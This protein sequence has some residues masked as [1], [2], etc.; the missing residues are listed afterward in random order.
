MKVL[1]VSDLR[2]N[3]HH[4]VKGA[5]PA[6]ECSEC[7]KILFGEV[8]VVRAYVRARNRAIRRV[9]AYD[10]EGIGEYDSVLEAEDLEQKLGSILD[11]DEYTSIPRCDI[12]G[13]K[14]FCG[15]EDCVV[16]PGNWNG[17]TGNH[18]SCEKRSFNF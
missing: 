1:D 7:S 3:D 12:C 13:H 9:S 11:L 10:N 16:C 4:G 8:G 17:E 18:V 5:P 15:V 2:C 14:E 6:K